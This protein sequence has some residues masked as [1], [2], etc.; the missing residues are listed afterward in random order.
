VNT[1]DIVY[2]KLH[3]H[4]TEH[5]FIHPYSFQDACRITNGNGEMTCRLSELITK[6]AYEEMERAEMQQELRN[7][8]LELIELWGSGP[9]K[10]SSHAWKKHVK[11]VAETLD[12]DASTIGRRIGMLARWGLIKDE[13][14][15]PDKSNVG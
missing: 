5:R 11:K 3:G 14:S 4:W 8:N 13:R 1:G 15:K 6:E 12:M 2:L 9:E 10:P 7:D